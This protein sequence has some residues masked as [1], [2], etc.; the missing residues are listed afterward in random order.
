[1]KILSLTAA[2]V[3]ALAATPLCAKDK[4]GEGVT[5][6]PVIQPTLEEMFQ[7]RVLFRAL[8]EL[9]YTVAEPQEVLAQ[10][11]HLAVGTGD[12]DFYPSSWNT[13]HDA[14]FKEAGGPEKISK[15]GTLVDGALQGYL[16]DKASYDAGVK[17]LGD[18]KDPAV[19][20]KFDVRRRR[21]S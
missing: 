21:Q 7:S 5:V 19:A 6:R 16:V 12:A 1:M 2:M 20:A 11:A 17:N 9:G 8:A 14:F 10:T 4:P 15:V 18:L 3:L 13:L